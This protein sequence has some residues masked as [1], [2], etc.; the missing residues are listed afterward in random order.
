MLGDYTPLVVSRGCVMLLRTMYE[1]LLTWEPIRQMLSPGGGS[2]VDSSVLTPIRIAIITAHI[3]TAFSAG[4]TF[5][6]TGY[7]SPSQTNSVG[8]CPPKL[9]I[10][11]WVS[12]VIIVTLVIQVLTILYVISQWWKKP[13]GF[14]ADPTSIAGIAAFMGHPE[15]EQEFVQIPTEI[16]YAGLK[17]RLKGKKFRLGQFA[18]ERGVVKYGIMPVE[19]EDG[20]PSKK[21]GFF[22]KL[23][24]PF[25]NFGSK[26]TW[27][28]NWKK[29]RYLFDILFVM[30]LV[31][32]LGLTIDAVSRYNKTQVVFLAT[33]SAHGT[34][35]RIFTAF[36]G[37][38]VSY[39]WGQIFQGKSFSSQN[40]LHLLTPLSRR[41]NIC[42]IHRSRT[43]LVRSGLHHPAQTPQHSFH[44]ILS[45][46]LALPLHTRNDCIHRPSRG[47]PH[48]L[49]LWI[50]LPTR[51]VK[52]R[53]PI[54]GHHLPL[55]PHNHAHPTHLPR[56]L[57]T[58]T[59]TPSKS[60]REYCVG[61]DLCGGHEHD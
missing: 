7:C 19:D 42:S 11:P 43:W 36:L 33:A 27:L 8:I 53:I 9:S 55:H 32:L 57:A 6:D 58:E 29:N 39:Y 46:H 47:T 26:F 5:F 41:S 61:H 38:V 50:A 59:P 16:N 56:H 20:N 12:D 30:L 21:D 49:A 51:T 52:G 1:Q 48:R 14:S 31:A 24:A 34:G 4:L 40:C 28:Q 25:S 22:D 18:T 17:K 37:V 23:K 15:I 13:G 54:L 60:T 10:N 3:G 45:P 2:L 35:W 44:S